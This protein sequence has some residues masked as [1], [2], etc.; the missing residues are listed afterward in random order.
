MLS[1]SE[2][3]EFLDQ[4]A[5]EFNNPNFI[6]SDPI[7]IPHRFSKREDIEIT[8][9]IMATIAWGN[10]KS[11]ISNGEKLLSLTG[12]Q[13]HEFVMNYDASRD[14]KFVHRT[15]NEIDLDFFFRS[16]QRVY[17]DSSLEQLFA[18]HTDH[19][20]QRG[21][22]IHFREQFLKT[23]HEGR[24]EKHIANPLKG[25]SAKRINMF[26]RWMCRQDNKGVDFG[27]WKSIPMSDLHLPL[28]VHTGNV[29]RKLG[30]LKRTQND[31]SSVEEIQQTLVQLDPKDPVKY[32]FALFGLGA[33]EGF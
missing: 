24:T 17:S 2:L 32:D 23:E 19:P 16:L 6:E 29:A 4:K 25:S 14:F 30:I 7:Q 28:D 20:G 12:N 15:F 11:I 18:S 27:L 26:L 5:E 21:R 1:F 9:L 33:F 22:I 8:A 10:R 31:W 3:K 13:P